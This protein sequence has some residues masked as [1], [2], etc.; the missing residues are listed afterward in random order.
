MLNL[1]NNF[2]DIK[3]KATCRDVALFKFNCS[4]SKFFKMTNKIELKVEMTF[5]S[6]FT[7]NDLLKRLVGFYY[8]FQETTNKF[9][10]QLEAAFGLLF[11][12]KC[13]VVS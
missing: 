3:K 1:Y 8:L 12:Y 5:T 7:T 6:S 4:P 13:I 2:V 11:F 9:F 10:T